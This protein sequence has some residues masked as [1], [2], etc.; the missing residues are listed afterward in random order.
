MA[1]REF[2][3]HRKKSSSGDRDAMSRISFQICMSFSWFRET[4]RE[5][6][7]NG[8]SARLCIFKCTGMIT[9]RADKSLKFSGRPFGDLI[10]NIDPAGDLEG[11]KMVKKKS[12]EVFFTWSSDFPEQ[13][14]PQYPHQERH[15]G[16][17]TPLPDV[18]R[19]GSSGPGLSQ[20]AIF[21]PR[22]Y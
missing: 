4:S 21:S 22:L 12:A 17:G 19:D 10:H 3:P 13:P 6:C 1:V 18:Q 16:Y 20:P 2:P 9:F 8:Y 14:L 5:S 11:D 7:I 15:H